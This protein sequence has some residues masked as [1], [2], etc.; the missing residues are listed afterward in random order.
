MKT[1]AV[2]FSVPEDVRKRL[3]DFAKSRGL[4]NASGLARYATIQYYNKYSKNAPHLH[5]DSPG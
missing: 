4:K 5:E 1:R 3:D 2:Q